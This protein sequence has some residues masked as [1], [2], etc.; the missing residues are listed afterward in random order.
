MPALPASLVLVGAGKMGGA[1]LRGWLA[2]GL[3]GGCMSVLDPN[4]SAEIAA[5]AAGAGVRLNPPSSAVTAPD[6]LVL[7]V[8][9]QVFETAAS[10]VVALVGEATLV[11]SIMAGK[12]RADIA[13]Q[14]PKAGAILRAMPNLP[15]SVGRGIT[16]VAANDAVPPRAR[17]LAE[18]LLSAVG[19][20]EWLDHEG[21]I[22]AVTAV[23]GSGPAYVFYL[24][25]CLAAAGA[26]AG[27][28]A[29]LARRLAR[30][31]VEGAGELMVRNPATAPGQLRQDVTSPGGTTEAA[32]AVLMRPEGL[33][34]L[35]I[36][37]VAAA[38]RRAGELAG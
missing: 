7:A 36:D 17:A 1:M 33:E 15:A 37:A 28:D 9:P 6:V 5:L 4:P 21:L 38:Q 3:E 12:T 10:S 31:T 2:L 25:E 18:T 32:L 26:A 23:S 14:L 13:A 16:A 24:V 19:K 8:K 35:I 34:R 22:D 30:A 20:V 29:D 27:L 11:L